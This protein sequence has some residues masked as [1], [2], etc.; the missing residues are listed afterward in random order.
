MTPPEHVT[1]SPGRQVILHAAHRPIDGDLH[2]G[3][4]GSF[5][6]LTGFFFSYA[7]A[8]LDAA[9]EAISVSHT[10]LVMVVL[11]F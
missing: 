11:P 1:L 4:T 2:E 10:S 8:G 3:P 5:F 7:A 9:S 6:S